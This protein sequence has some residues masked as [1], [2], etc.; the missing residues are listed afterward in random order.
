MNAIRNKQS[1]YIFK[2][3]YVDINNIKEKEITKVS[4][5]IESFESKEIEYDLEGRVIKETANI[6][7][8][9]DKESTRVSSLVEVINND[10]NNLKIGQRLVVTEVLPY[11]LV[12]CEI[13]EKFE[14]SKVY[15]LDTTD[16]K[17]I[18]NNC[19]E[20]FVTYLGPKCTK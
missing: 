14:H 4:K 19:L 16:L 11:P 17:L 15:L 13:K 5:L 7:Y 9:Y 10:N 18:S 12:Q 1:D 3:K 2:L 8:V 20:Q 6:K